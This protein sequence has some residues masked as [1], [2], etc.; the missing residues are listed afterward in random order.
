MTA[1]GRLTPMQVDDIKAKAYK[2]V[3]DAAIYAEGCD[4]PTLESIEEGVYAE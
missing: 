2:V 4:D 3:G 1:E